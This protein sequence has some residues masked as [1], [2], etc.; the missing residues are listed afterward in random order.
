MFP[1][2]VFMMTRYIET[3]PSDLY[4]AAFVEGASH[5]R[6]LSSIVV[7]LIVPAC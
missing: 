5:V 4:E 3:I 6:I 1:F 2:S 7:P